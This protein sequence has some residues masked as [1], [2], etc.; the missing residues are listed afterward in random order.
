MRAVPN[1][2]G[3]TRQ[4]SSRIG[5]CDQMSYLTSWGFFRAVI[6]LFGGYILWLLRTIQIYSITTGSIQTGMFWEVH[7]APKDCVF[8]TKIHRQIQICYQSGILGWGGCTE[9]CALSIDTRF[10]LFGFLFYFIFG[11][12]D[13]GVPLLS[14]AILGSAEVRD[15]AT[16][17]PRRDTDF[18]IYLSLNSFMEEDMNDWMP[19]NIEFPRWYLAWCEAF[20]MIYCPPC[21]RQTKYVCGLPILAQKNWAGILSPPKEKNILLEVIKEALRKQMWIPLGSGLSVHCTWFR[22]APSSTRSY[23][24]L[25]T[26][27]PGEL[28]YVS[29][30]SASISV[31]WIKFSQSPKIH[32]TDL[33]NCRVRFFM[34]TELRHAQG[35][36]SPGGEQAEAL[37][38]SCPKEEQVLSKGRCRIK[39]LVPF[40]PLLPRFKKD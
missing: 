29:T 6:Q 18:T 10:G 9:P 27:S 35:N 40:K 25:F 30:A 38:R 17:C 12:C 36:L 32:F 20:L 37:G 14:A 16:T 13:S 7:L 4:G 26:T 28:W 15:T 31:H 5:R 2:P 22:P 34:Q 33:G 8:C 24:T 21:F 23:S 19:L 11:V 3:D 1:H 39:L